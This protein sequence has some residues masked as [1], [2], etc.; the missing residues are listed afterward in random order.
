MYNESLFVSR[1]ILMEQ[2]DVFL[3]FRICLT[4]FRTAKGLKIKVK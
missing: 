1:N 4:Q 3:Y 2:S